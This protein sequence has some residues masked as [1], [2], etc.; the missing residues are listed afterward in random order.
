VV[1]DALKLKLIRREVTIDDWF[2]TRYLQN[3]LKKQGLENYWTAYDAK[4]QPKAR[5]S[6]AAN[7]R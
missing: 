6:V 3:A 5:Q 4:G 2:D 1:A 7:G